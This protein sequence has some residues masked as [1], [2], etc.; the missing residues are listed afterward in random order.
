MTD[1]VIGFGVKFEGTI[2]VPN[3]ARI[4]GTV[5]GNL[6]A[7]EIEV[8]HTGLIDGSATAPTINVHGEITQETRCH[9]LLKI[10]SSGK[11]RGNVQYGEL[12]ISRGG[13]L[14]GKVQSNN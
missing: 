4:S 12:E 5:I 13:K 1:L 11:V 6:S 8:T 10:G 2:N 9:H 7:K 3:N 14:T